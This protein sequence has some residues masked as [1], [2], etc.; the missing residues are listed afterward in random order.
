MTMLLLVSSTIALALLVVHS[1]RTRGRAVTLAFFLSGLLFGVLRGNAVYYLLLYTSGGASEGLKPY[2]PEESILPQIGH[3][4]LQVAVGWIFAAYL[5]WTVSEMVLRRLP[6]LS[7]RVFM[8]GGI[9]SLFMVAICW[10]M[11]TTAVAVGWWYWTLPTATAAFGNV[12][13]AGMWAWFSIAPDFLI[14]FLVI[15]CSAA[16]RPVKWLWLLV[17]PLHMLGHL[18]YAWWAHAYLIY[19][20]LVL[21]VLAPMAFSRLR[22]SRGEIGDATLLPYGPTRRGEACAESAPCRSREGAAHNRVASPVSL[23]AALAIFF[24]VILAANVLSRTA[25]ETPL[26]ALPMLMLC[27]LAWRRLP[28]T[29][30]VGLALVGLAGWT[31]MGPRALWVLAPVGVYGFLALLDRLR[32][33]L[34]LRLVPPVAAVILAAA[35]SFLAS[36][37]DKERMQRYVDDWVEGD[38]LWLA[39]SS[40]EAE[41]AYARSDA[42]RPHDVLLLYECVRKMTEIDMRDPRRG[43][44]LLQHRLLVREVGRRIGYDDPYHF[45]KTFKRVYGL[46]PEVFRSHG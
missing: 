11:E 17:F 41:A 19:P 14:P 27:L 38:R 32:E 30:V 6:R 35:A 12:N 9:A 22:M 2:M 46:A 43:T 26:T 36:E 25:P 13:T 20:A 34:W 37:A 16:R 45:S 42:S 23:A 7:G 10:C 5:A 15:A 31:W 39:S 33:P 3:E 40:W 24:G 29:A 18:A 28:V 1:W 4:S 21:V 44:L 8:I